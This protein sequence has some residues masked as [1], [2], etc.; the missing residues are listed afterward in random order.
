MSAGLLILPWVIVPLCLLYMTFHLWL[1]CFVTNRLLLW[2]NACL[3]G[4]LWTT[5]WLNPWNPQVEVGL[6]ISIQIY[7]CVISMQWTPRTP[8]TLIKQA[9]RGIIIFLSLGKNRDFSTT[10]NDG[11]FLTS[12]QDHIWSMNKNVVVSFYLSVS[13]ET[14]HKL[15]GLTWCNRVNTCLFTSV[16]LHFQDYPCQQWW[17][18]IAKTFCG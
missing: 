16:Q 2:F 6:Y 18:T 4:V 5:V 14:W 3:W 11:V 8:L 10:Y 7:T 1:K 12:P 9:S 13:H 17:R 15:L